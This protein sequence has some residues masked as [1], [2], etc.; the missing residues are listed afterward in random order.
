MPR[1]VVISP[2]D[3]QGL[4]KQEYDAAMGRA[5]RIWHIVSLMSQNPV[6]MQTCMRFYATL[7]FGSSPL[8]RSQREML[9]TVVSA[10]NHCR[11]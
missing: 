4:L 6:A 9:A 2:E 5:G 8:N 10:T 7:M 11:Y 1:I 3:A